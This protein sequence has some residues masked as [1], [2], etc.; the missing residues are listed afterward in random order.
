ML[1]LP[2]HKHGGELLTVTR[3]ISLIMEN[4]ITSRGF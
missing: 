3:I 4:I 1:L 2:G